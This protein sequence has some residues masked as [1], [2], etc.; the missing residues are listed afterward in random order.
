[1]VKRHSLVQVNASRLGL[2]RNGRELKA[3]APGAGAAKNNF[4]TRS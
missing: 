1:M 4:A 3:L 2:F